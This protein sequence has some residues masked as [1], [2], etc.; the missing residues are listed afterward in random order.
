MAFSLM[1]HLIKYGSQERRIEKMGIF[2]PIMHRICLV[3]PVVPMNGIEKE[4]AI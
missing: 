2:P 4:L 1:I 3:F